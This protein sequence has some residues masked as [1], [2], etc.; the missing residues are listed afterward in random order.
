MLKKRLIFTLLVNKG[1]FQLSRNFSLQ[2]VGSFDWLKKHYELASISRSID[3]L[4]L[5]N[6]TRGEK[7]AALFCESVSQLSTL[8]FTPIAAGGGIDSMDDA[9]RLLDAGADKLVINSLLFARPALVEELAKTFGSQCVV[10]SLDYRRQGDR[11]EVYAEAAKRHAGYTLEA[12]ARRAEDVGAGELYVTSVERDGTGQ[13]Y[14]VEALE[15]VAGCCRLPVIA[16]GGVGDFDH[17][18]QG[19]RVRGVS[20]ASTANIFNFMGDGLTKARGFIEENGIELAKW[21]FSSS[22]FADRAIAAATGRSA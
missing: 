18:V 19:L 17:F 1:V 8:C 9:Y 5:L 11:L 22:P 14:D 16:S 21:D 3:E 6:V 2:A 7:L 13:G 4:V 12:A 15:L 20:A 10:A